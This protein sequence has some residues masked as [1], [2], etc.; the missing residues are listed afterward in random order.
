MYKEESAN[1]DQRK[2]KEPVLSKVTIAFHIVTPQHDP[3][4]TNNLV[5][6]IPILHT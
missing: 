6:Y 1:I 4:N 3:V 5:I 2:C